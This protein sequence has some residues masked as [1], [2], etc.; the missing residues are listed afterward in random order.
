MEPYFRVDKI[1]ANIQEKKNIPIS[2]KRLVFAR[3]ELKDEQTLDECNVSKE[4]TLHLILK[5]DTF[6]HKVIEANA[7]NYTCLIFIY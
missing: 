4:C 7:E 3:K 2:R 6:K 1:K 5:K